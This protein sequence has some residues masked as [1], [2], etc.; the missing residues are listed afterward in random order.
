[1][2]LKKPRS[3]IFP[4]GTG[5]TPLAGCW[6]KKK[7]SS[8]SPS[9]KWG[10][11]HF[12]SPLISMVGAAQPSPS[13]RV[14]QIV[15]S[16]F[17]RTSPWH[18]GTSVTQVLPSDCTWLQV[19]SARCP[20]AVLA[21]SNFHPEQ[22]GALRR[23]E[24]GERCAFALQSIWPEPDNPNHAFRWEGDGRTGLEDNATPGGCRP[25]VNFDRVHRYF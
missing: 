15:P 5:E 25:Q 10:R 8:Q 4:A 16:F 12:N 6:F 2:S 17:G 24:K 3:D 19:N 9:F 21:G 7:K 11:G 1:M 18:H 20:F 23:A 14:A 13:W 22:T